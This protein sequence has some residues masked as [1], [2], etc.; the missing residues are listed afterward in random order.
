MNQVWDV[1]GF[2]AFLEKMAAGHQIPR[3]LASGFLLLATA[4]L[5]P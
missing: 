1:S 4:P 3:R 2:A 5:T